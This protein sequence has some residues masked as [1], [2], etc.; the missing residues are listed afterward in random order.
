[1]WPFLPGGGEEHGLCIF[2][3]VDGVCPSS[4]LCRCDATT[5]MCYFF[6]ES[7]TN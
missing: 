1:M 6:D 7:D 5:N 2:N 4:P 3:C